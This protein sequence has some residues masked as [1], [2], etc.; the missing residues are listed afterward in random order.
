MPLSEF[1]PQLASALRLPEM[2]ARPDG[3]CAFRVGEVTVQLIPRPAGENAFV[4]RACL[5]RVDGAARAATLERLLGANFFGNGVG[6]PVLGLDAQDTVFL[7]QHFPA[8]GL[9]FDGLFIALERFVTHAG[10][11]R[12]LLEQTAAPAQEMGHGY[13]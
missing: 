9:G 10:E 11:C 5:G 2:V 1:I 6:G 7:T 13:A 4:A 8:G 12:V 3:A